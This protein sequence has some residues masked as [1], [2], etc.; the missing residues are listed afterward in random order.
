[1]YSIIVT[2]ILY[3]FLYFKNHYVVKAE[4]LLAGNVVRCLMI[5]E[6]RK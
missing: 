3:V 4:Y 1:M 6:V 2:P 5:C